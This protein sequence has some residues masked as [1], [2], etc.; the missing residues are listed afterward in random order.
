MSVLYCVNL[1]QLYLKDMLAF[2]VI[3]TNRINSCFILFFIGNTPFIIKYGE[4]R[5]IESKIN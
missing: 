5:G 1:E 2:A 3:K 4:I